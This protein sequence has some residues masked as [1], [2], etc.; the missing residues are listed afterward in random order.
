MF[1]HKQQQAIKFVIRSKL[2]EEQ[3]V[4]PKPTA[5]KVESASKLSTESALRLEEEFERKRKRAEKDT[6]VSSKKIHT[7]LQK[8]NQKKAELKDPLE[9]KNSAEI[10]T[11][12]KLSE[13]STKESKD[14]KEETETKQKKAEK[15]ADEEDD[16]ATE[17]KSEKDDDFSD[18]VMN[19]CLLCQR[20]FKSGQDLEKHQE[21]SELHK[22]NLQ[23]PVVIEKA[24]MKKRFVKSEAEKAEE[25]AVEQSVGE[26]VRVLVLVLAFSI[27]ATISVTATISISASISERKKRKDI[28]YLGYSKLKSLQQHY[29]NRAAERRQAYGQPEKPSLSDSIHRPPPRLRPDERPTQSASVKKALGDDNVGA[30]ML[31]LMGWRR[32]EGLGKD[33]SGIVDP[34]NAER[35]SQGAGLGTAYAKRDASDGSDSYKDRVKEM[36]RRRFEEGP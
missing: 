15:E 31:K 26:R 28:L 6:L 7:Q 29:R 34:I 35:Y 36:A 8:W 9:D 19:A 2:S 17:N 22:K 21:L 24:R 12:S 20:K 4:A 25:R 27:G 13:P 32:G 18:R 16:A 11:K 5:E 1:P 33:G 14:S 3:V 10:E 23:D 30:R